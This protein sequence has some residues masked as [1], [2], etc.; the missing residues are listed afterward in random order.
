MAPVSATLAS[1]GTAATIAASLCIVRG[2]PLAIR[3]RVC[4][5]TVKSLSRL[6]DFRSYS[7]ILESQWRAVQ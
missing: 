1:A 3:I 5:D 7:T 4:L 6:R 2:S